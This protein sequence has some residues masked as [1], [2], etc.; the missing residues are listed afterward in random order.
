MMTCTILH[1]HVPRC[2]VNYIITYGHALCMHSR[3]HAGPLVR[4][5][6]QML[7]GAICTDPIECFVVS[8]SLSVVYYIEYL[9]SDQQL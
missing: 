3:A 2:N 9:W 1:W 4:Q 7:D 8:S 6:E 5:P